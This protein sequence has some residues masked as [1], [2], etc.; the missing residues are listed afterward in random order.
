MNP[1]RK[2]AG[3]TAM[4]GVSSILGRLLNY[5]LVPLHT[6][7]FMPDQLGIIVVLYAYV[8]FL[9]VVFTFGLET[10]F[11]RY[12]KEGN[13][14]PIYQNATS[15]VF[16]I[17]F[18]ISLLIGFMAAHIANY[19]DYPQHVN[20]IQWLAIIIFLDA[21]VAIPFARLR[22]ENKA[23]K[24]A[25][26]RISSIIL[27][28]LLNLYFLGIPYAVSNLGWNWLAPFSMMAF[29]ALTVDYIILAN[30]LGNII[31]IPLLWKELR[32]LRPRLDGPLTRQMLS[33]AF[34]I[35][36]MGLGGIASEQL[37]K[38]ML[39]MLLPDGFYADQST[40]AAVG[41]YGNLM[42]LSIFM[43]LATQAF[44]YAGEPFFFSQAK[45]KNAPALFAKVMHYFIVSCV[46]LYVAVSL[47]VDLIANIFLRN[48]A[49]RRDLEIVPLLLLGKLFFGIYMNLSIWFKLSDRTIWGTYLSLIGAGIT[50]LGNI[51][52]IPVLG[53]HGAALT[54]V[55]CYFLLCAISYLKGQQ[56]YPIPYILKPVFI[57]IGGSTLLIYLALIYIPHSNAGIA[58]KA[59]LTLL[60]IGIVFLIEKRKLTQKSN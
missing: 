52:L 20:L 55:G 5:A 33:Y 59:S 28:V 23:K 42:K 50:L 17:S 43:M 1:L 18:S 45:D 44:R 3:D 6:A 51:L 13:Q 32:L 7:V 37:D 4:Y 60:F 56:N 53:Y 27:T 30:L 2:L 10:A 35:M 9:N 48:E 12:A 57:Y 21:F 41:V 40:A 34:P 38:I 29:E 47:N 46:I 26:I 25:F 54:M 24:F 58:M 19:L 31:Y 36:L 49:Y 16:C 8:A 22:F 39:P 15:L 14:L 11:F